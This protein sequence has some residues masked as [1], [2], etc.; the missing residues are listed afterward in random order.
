LIFADLI[1]HFAPF[2]ATTVYPVM[3]VLSAGN[4]QDTNQPFSTLKY[5]PT[6]V[7]TGMAAL[8]D[9]ILIAAIARASAEIRRMDF[10]MALLDVGL[11]QKIALTHYLNFKG[12][13]GYPSGLNRS[14]LSF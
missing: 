4:V 5:A 11:G 7:T 2:D 14:S 13:L 9:G 8:A 3:P 1:T 6:S 12:M 10:F